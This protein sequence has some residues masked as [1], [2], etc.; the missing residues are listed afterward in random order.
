[1]PLGVLAHGMPGTMLRWWYPEVWAIVL[2]FCTIY[3]FLIGPFR[4]KHNL[5]PR[6]ELKDTL[7]FVAAM[8]VMFVSEGTPIHHVSEKFLF[9]MHMTQHILLTMVMAPLLI[10]GTPPWLISYGLRFPWIRKTMKLITHPVIA[11]I[12]FNAINAAWHLPF[13]YQA[14]LLHHWIHI[15]Q[16]IVFVFTSLMMWWPILSR[17]PELPRLSYGVQTLYIFVLLLLQLPVF[18]PI[19]FS[20]SLWYDFYVEAPTMFGLEPL[21]DQ[22]LAGAV[23]Q[24]GGMTVMA[25]FMGRAFFRWVREETSPR[26]RSSQSA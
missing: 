7:Y 16:H 22:Q 1:M 6:A 14:V 5:A 24:L 18:A 23:M 13:F 3:F 11:I 17:S 10:M 21:P 8:F 9:S 15:V 20:E 26:Y 4:E 25:I 12:A 19:I 2:A